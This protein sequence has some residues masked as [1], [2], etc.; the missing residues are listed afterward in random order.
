MACPGGRLKSRPK[1]ELVVEEG[2]DPAL[3]NWTWPLGPEHVNNRDRQWMERNQ[4]RK[5]PSPTDQKAGL[6]FRKRGRN[7]EHFEFSICI[8]NMNELKKKKAAQC[9]LAFRAGRAKNLSLS[10]SKLNKHK[11]VIIWCW[12][13]STGDWVTADCRLSA[14]S[15]K[16]FTKSSLPVYLI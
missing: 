1:R 3:E 13:V 15:D 12:W 8:C 2:G 14:S 9:S 5:L 11:I 16:H 4:R 10:D 7:H 6:A